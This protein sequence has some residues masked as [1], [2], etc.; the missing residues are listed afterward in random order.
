MAL[1][2][3]K[4]LVDETDTKEKP[5]ILHTYIIVTKLIEKQP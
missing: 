2:I 4:V 5:K 3:G 1:N